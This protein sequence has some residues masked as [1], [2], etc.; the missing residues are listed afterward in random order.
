VVCLYAGDRLGVLLQTS[1]RDE[2]DEAVFKYL[3]A[4]YTDT[5]LVKVRPR[6][7]KLW[8]ALAAGRR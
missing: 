7:V 2:F 8:P 1:S 3:V 6:S 4:I 5:E